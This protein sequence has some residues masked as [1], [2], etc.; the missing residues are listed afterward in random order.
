MKSIYARAAAL[1]F[2]LA[3]AATAALAQRPPAASDPATPP[4]ERQTAAQPVTAPVKVKYEG[5]LLGF[6]K[7]EGWLGFDD[8]NR[9]LVFKNKQQRELFS[10]SF[11]AVLAA[12]PDTK[13]RR[14]T[15]GQVI[16]ST[17][18]F[19]LGLPALLM[20]SK[21]RYLV[22]QYRDPDTRAEGVTSFKMQNKELIASVLSA[23]AQKAQLT[24][25]G[26][27]YVRRQDATTTRTS[28]PE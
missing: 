27:A 16:A 14:S 4:A 11:D 17:A 8:L 25:R 20:K 19:G 28:A 1:A 10:L 26:E 18:P 12:W 7:Q 23:L 3:L 15:A 24:Q 6:P 2:A 9:R 21:S 13:S 22:L 5:G